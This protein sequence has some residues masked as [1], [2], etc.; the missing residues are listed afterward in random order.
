MA[1]GKHSGRLEDNPVT[2]GRGARTRKDYT[3]HVLEKDGTRRSY[4]CGASLTGAT[5]VYQAIKDYGGKVV[6]NLGIVPTDHKEGPASPGL[7]DAAEVER[8]GE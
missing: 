2:N 3:V 6:A 8:W 5:Q 1:K 4:P 7:V